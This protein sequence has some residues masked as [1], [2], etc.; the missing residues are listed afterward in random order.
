MSRLT[1]PA[2][3]ELRTGPRLIHSRIFEG[4]RYIRMMFLC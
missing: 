4:S 1:G 2:S 3:G